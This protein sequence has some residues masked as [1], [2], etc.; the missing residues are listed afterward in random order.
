[1][2]IGAGELYVIRLYIYAAIA[3]AFIGFLAYVGH[4]KGK[5]DKY[6]QAKAELSAYKGA[7]EARDKQ[8]AI[9]RAEAEKRSEVLSLKLENTKQTLD[10]L[11]SHPITRVVYREKIVNGVSCPDPRLGP[12]VLKLWN[13]QANTGTHAVSASD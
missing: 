13:D 12:D 9:D 8:A 3:L 6:D 7:V 10:D 5:A 1:V 2:D 4:I 11:R